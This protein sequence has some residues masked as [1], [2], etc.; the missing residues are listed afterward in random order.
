[1][2]FRSLISLNNNN[3]NNNNNDNNNNNNNNNND[4]NNNNNNDNKLA[5]QGSNPSSYNTVLKGS[6]V[7]F[8]FLSF[9]N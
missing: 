3:N 6:K 2:F 8:A 7:F 5:M 4:N 9:V 1:M